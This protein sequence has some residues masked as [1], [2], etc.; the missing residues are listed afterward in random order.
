MNRILH[1]GLAALLL[2]QTALAQIDPYAALDR[3]ISPFIQLPNPGL[4]S[5]EADVEFS[6]TGLMDILRLTKS[7][8]LEQPRFVEKMGADG[9]LALTIANQSY[10][11]DVVQNLEMQLLPFQLFFTTTRE[12][13]R[14]ELLELRGRSEAVTSD[15]ELGGAQCLLVE[16]KPTGEALQIQ[17]R[18][19]PGDMQ[20]ISRTKRA[21]YWI[22]KGNGTI[23]RIE[24]N[25]E[26]TDQTADGTPQGEILHRELWYEIDYEEVGKRWVP[27]RIL[28]VVDRID[29]F[30]Q[31]I[32]YR[33]EGEYVVFDRRTTHYFQ[34]DL[35]G[36]RATAIAEY[37]DYRFG[38]E[39]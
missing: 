9:T 28:Q 34:A 16:L 27:T 33:L 21:A 18:Q 11:V 1:A 22:D 12:A 39:G 6:G 24:S 26:S 10:P 8:S 19:L 36:M 29:A 17:G 30:E 13:N 14:Q 37:Q 5:Y 23:R 15:V 38:S 31:L 2:A 7:Q 3:A 35:L 4:V 20:R 25:S 32:S